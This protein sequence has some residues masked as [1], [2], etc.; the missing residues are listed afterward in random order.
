[1]I[2]LLAEI[3]RMR[4]EQGKERIGIGTLRRGPGSIEEKCVGTWRTGRRRGEKE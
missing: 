4:G 1:V 2:S 3:T